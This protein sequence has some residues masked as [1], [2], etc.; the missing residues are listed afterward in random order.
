MARRMGR[1]FLDSVSELCE[2]LASLVISFVLICLAC[3]WTLVESEA[4]D[5]KTNAV[6]TMLR[7]PR[8]LFKGGA[9]AGVV[10]VLVATVFNLVLVIWNKRSVRCSNN[11]LSFVPHE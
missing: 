10:L 8:K 11:P 1:Y 6:A 7:D 9:N 4:D 2:G 3:G 5:R